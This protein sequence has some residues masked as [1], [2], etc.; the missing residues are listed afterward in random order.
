MHGCLSLVFVVCCATGRSLIQRSPT[1]RRDCGSLINKVTSETH[2]V[3]SWE[4][5]T[6]RT[7]M[8]AVC[9]RL[10]FFFFYWSGGTRADVGEWAQWTP[11]SPDFTV[12]SCAFFFSAYSKCRWP[13]KSYC[14]TLHDQKPWA[15]FNENSL[16]VSRAE[17]TCGETR[18][19]LYWFCEIYV[20]TALWFKLCSPICR[21][22]GS[23]SWLICGRCWSL[24]RYRLVFFFFIY[25]WLASCWDVGTTLPP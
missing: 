18:D 14:V 6:W 25:A 23:M 2:D 24:Y 13:N 3:K 20:V 8:V 15:D 9:I 4:S 11:A 17:F 16:G 1:G 22:G 10:C 7:L 12:C 5:L 19:H 21:W